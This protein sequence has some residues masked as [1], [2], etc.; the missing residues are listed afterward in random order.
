MKLRWG[1]ERIKNFSKPV[2]KVERTGTWL[3]LLTGSVCIGTILWL[4]YKIAQLY[5]IHL[6]VNSI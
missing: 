3:W 1:N 6:W 2:I 5:A 4:W